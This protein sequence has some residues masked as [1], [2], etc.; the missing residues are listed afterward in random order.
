MDTAIVTITCPHC[1]GE[2]KGIQALAHEQTVPCTFCGTE[3][4]VPH[5][6]DEI[7][8]EVIVQAPPA[9]PSRDPVYTPSLRPSNTPVRIAVGLVLLC[10]AMIAMFALECDADT[11]IDQMNRDEATESACKASCKQTC[12]Q[13]PPK[14]PMTSTGDDELDRDTARTMQ[15]V[16]RMECD[17]DCEQQHDCRHLHAPPR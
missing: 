5:V 11:T 16:D 14:H 6:G 7:V 2:V 15:E 4:H 8:R 10:V 1:G 13:A 9:A 12:E 3:L 17:N